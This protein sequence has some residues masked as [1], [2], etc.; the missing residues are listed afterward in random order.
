MTHYFSV[1]STSL[2]RFYRTLPSERRHVS[3]TV[4]P[5]IP[6]PSILPNQEQAEWQK[7]PSGVDLS[8]EESSMEVEIEKKKSIR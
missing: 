1:F 3:Y 7:V 2:F 4:N 5:F 8:C 6:P